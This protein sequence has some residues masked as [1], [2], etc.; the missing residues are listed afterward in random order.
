MGNLCNGKLAGSLYVQN[1]S[2]KCLDPGQHFI[3]IKKDAGVKVLVFTDP[4]DFSPAS[5]PV[6]AVQDVRFLFLINIKLDADLFK[7]ASAASKGH[8]P[9]FPHVLVQIS[10]NLIISFIWLQD[11]Y[12]L[13]GI[14]AGTAE[15][16]V[17]R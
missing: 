10:Q 7:A 2:R 3:G 1:P 9:A 6:K 8:S 13:D 14:Q 11:I 15:P 16:A 17:F 12:L 4:H 5:L